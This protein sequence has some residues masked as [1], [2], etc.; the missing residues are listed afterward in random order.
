M[1]DVACV[2]PIQNIHIST[3]YKI[4]VNI[5]LQNRFIVLNLHLLK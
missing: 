2:A 1:F 3:T 5:M 4:C